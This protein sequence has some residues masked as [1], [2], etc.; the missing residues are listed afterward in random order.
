MDI[1]GDAFGKIYEYFLSK[2]A[3]TEG[4]KGG[5]FFTP[6]S[7]VKLIV[8]V[9]EPYHG[10]IFDP[11]CGSGGMFV[12]SARFVGNHKKNPNAEISVYG[13]EKTAGETRYTILGE[14]QGKILMVVLIQQSTQSF[15]LLTA[16]EPSD[17]YKNLY[18]ERCK[19]WYQ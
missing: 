3:M 4:Q 6:T 2:F 8:E 13:Q 16:Y 7:I 5:E 9:I 14:S 17:G 11:A 12:Q 10:R 19:K 1:E 18:R 15:Y